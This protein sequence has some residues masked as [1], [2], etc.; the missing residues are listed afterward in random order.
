MAGT[1]KCVT[2]LPNQQDPVSLTEREE[3]KTVQSSL[4]KNNPC[5]ARTRSGVVLFVMFCWWQQNI[6]AWTTRVED[7]KYLALGY[8]RTYRKRKA[9]IAVFCSW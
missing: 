2:H 7:G 4:G 1:Q 6:L 9:I 5:L 8:A 3:K